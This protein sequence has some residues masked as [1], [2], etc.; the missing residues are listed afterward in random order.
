[1]K[2]FSTLR[3]E[4]RPLGVADEAMYR[5]L[6]TS[7]DVMTHVGPP[8]EKLAA[9]RGFK[10]S[11]GLNAQAPW[12]Q[13]RWAIREHGR[14]P[15]L[16]MLALIRDPPGSGS[17]EIGIMLLAEAQ[18]RGVALEVTTATVSLVF[19]SPGLGLRRI[20]ARHAPGHVASAKVLEAS[21]FQSGPARG[22][23]ATWTI[24]I[25]RW[26]ALGH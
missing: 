15:P 24:S 19:S 4:M 20:W 21:G 18:G 3:F 2:A 25:D 8:L 16:G 26:L 23:E 7:A 9:Q 14:A 11:C 5:R 13:L 12:T 22:Q 10:A 1:M 17:A 6:Y